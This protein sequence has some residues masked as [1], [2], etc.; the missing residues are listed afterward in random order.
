MQLINEMNRDST[1][2]WIVLLQIS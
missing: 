2:S 1:N